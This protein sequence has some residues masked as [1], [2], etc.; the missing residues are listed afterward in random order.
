MPTMSLWMPR[1]RYFAAA[2]LAP[3]I[4]Q[5]ACGNGKIGPGAEAE[6][7]KPV[8][9]GFFTVAA[10]Q[11]A[12]LRVVT[13]GT[14]VWQTAVVT[15]G[16][17]DWDADHTT[18]AITQVNGPISRILVDTGSKVKAGDPLLFVSS[19]DVANAIS[20]YRKARNREAF[21]KRIVDR[22]NILLDRGAVAAKDVESSVAD[23]NDARTDVQTSLQ[24]LRIFGIT[25]QEIDQAEQQ[26]TAISTELAVRA[27]ISGVVVQKLVSPGMLIQAGTTVCFMLSDPSTVWVWGHIF[28]RDLPSVRTGDAVEETNPASA[29]TFRGVVNYMGAFVDPATRTTPV[30]IVTQNPEGLL[31][32]DMFVEASIHTGTQ[33]NVLAVPT[34][35]V[36][37]D[38]KNEPIV[39]VQVEPGKFAQRSVTIGTQQD[40][41]VAITGG[42]QKGETV[43]AD[44]SLFVQFATSIQ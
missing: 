1:R 22:M 32:K 25:Q 37:R 40:S 12:H 30:R 11:M 14:R 5:C 3:G 31:K 43:L 8:Q 21:N 27:P 20:A 35:A 41:M 38:D 23:Y 42:L 26:G 34:A 17:V 39:Y 7:A 6:Q 36:L 44:G 4:F 13:V 16:T 10:D 29:R 18:Q 19:P 33:S 9:A 15:T 24:A 28:D 2:L